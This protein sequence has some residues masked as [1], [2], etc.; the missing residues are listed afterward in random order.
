MLSLRSLG[1]ALCVLLVLLPVTSA[2]KWASATA[3]LPPQMTAA[4][5]AHCHPS[6][7]AQS[8]PVAIR[9]S[10]TVPADFPLEDGKITCITCHENTAEGHNQAAKTSL[11]R[12][13]FR[14]PAFCAQCHITDRISAASMHP[15]ALARA[16]LASTEQGGAIE[17][18]I[19]LSCH[20]GTL[21]PDSFVNAERPA[22]AIITPAANGHPIDMAYPASGRTRRGQVLVGAGLLDRRLRLDRGQV[23][24]GTCHSLYSTQPSLLV[25]SNH[26]SQLCLSC[27]IDD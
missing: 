24:C 3:T 15:T 14:G 20:D 10:M 17:S 22:S 25:M 2:R 13:R 12:G 21:A 6:D 7:A 8:H 27:H 23:T 1:I 19:C 5:C 4:Q 9:P 16:H 18:R 26:S 11:V